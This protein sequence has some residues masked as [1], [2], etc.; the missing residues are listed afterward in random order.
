M[1]LHAQHQLYTATVPNIITCHHLEGH[2]LQVRH[3]QDCGRVFNLLLT[4]DVVLP[5]SDAGSYVVKPALSFVIQNCQTLHSM[6]WPTYGAH[7]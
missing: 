3:K 7:Y 6:W 2:P 1:L 4:Q 5:R